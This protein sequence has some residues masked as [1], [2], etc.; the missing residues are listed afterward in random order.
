VL[1]TAAASREAALAQSPFGRCADLYQLWMRYERHF[2]LHSSQKARADIAL[3]RDCRDGRQACGVEELHKLLRRGLIPIPDR[4][5]T[6]EVG[7]TPTAR[8]RP[9]GRLRS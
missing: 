9:A 5:I 1:A 3:E 2:T 6:T 8:T 7:S 4:E